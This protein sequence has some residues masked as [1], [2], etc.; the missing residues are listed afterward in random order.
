MDIEQV[1]RDFTRLIQ[2]VGLLSYRDRLAKL[3]LT[4]LIERRM[5]GDLIETFKI[6]KGINNYGSGLYKISRGGTKLMYTSPKVS[7]KSG[8][9]TNR[10]VEYWNKLPADIRDGPMTVAQFKNALDVLKKDQKSSTGNFWELSEE[11]FSRINEDSRAIY[12]SYLVEN[13][14]VMYRRNITCS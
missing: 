9:L 14:S 12:V 3:G 10:V 1:Q 2:D 5:R 6:L 11:V 13:P 8:F 4:T 7:S